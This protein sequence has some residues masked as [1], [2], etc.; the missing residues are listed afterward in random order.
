[1]T[2]SRQ[3]STLTPRLVRAAL[4]AAFLLITACAA[5][6]DDAAVRDVLDERTGITVTRL[7]RA[8]ELSVSV[9]RGPAGD[10]FAYLGIF[11]TN[12]MGERAEFVWLAVPSGAQGVQAMAVEVNGRALDLGAASDDPQLAG[13]AAS[14]Y[15]VPAPWSVVRYFRADRAQMA[16]IANATSLGIRVTHG[17]DISLFAAA[18]GAD[19]PLRVF[20]RQL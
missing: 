13:L 4:S 17:T 12:H 5:V 2:S 3:L 14:P 16:A 10:P 11:E 20:A 8:V 6:P 7:G 19:H 9:G 15:P 1:M 18:I